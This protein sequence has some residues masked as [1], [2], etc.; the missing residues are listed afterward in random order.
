MKTYIKGCTSLLLVVCAGTSFA[1]GSLEPSDPPGMTMKTLDQVE[2]RTPVSVPGTLSTS[3]SYYLTNNISGT[4]V[5]GADHVDLDLNGFTVFDG[6]AAGA[7]DLDNRRNVRIHG[8]SVNDGTGRGI[9]ANGSGELFLSDI[10]M[11]GFVNECIRIGTPTGPIYLERIQCYDT[12]EGGIFISQS[13]A[14]PLHAE[15]RDSVVTNANTSDLVTVAGLTIVHIGT[16]DMYVVVTRNRI[17][18]SRV[19]GYDIDCNSCAAAFGEISENLAQDNGTPGPGG[20]GFLVDGDFLVAKNRAVGNVINYS[21][22]SNRD[23]P[24]AALDAN[25][26]PWD[27]ITE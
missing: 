3:G 13:E 26:G 5:I 14:N 18:G 1:Q 16:G 8:G 25:P 7:I 12:G 2:A 11:S 24:T 21:V 20:Y 27:N 15:V 6:P 22:T 4:I 17:T 9:S 23:A 19:R 10:R